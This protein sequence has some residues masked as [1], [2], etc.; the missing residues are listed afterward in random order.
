[1]HLETHSSLE[2]FGEDKEGAHLEEERGALHEGLRE[3]LESLRRSSWLLGDYME[4]ISME[5]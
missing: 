2:I 3:T 1:V 5:S 4:S